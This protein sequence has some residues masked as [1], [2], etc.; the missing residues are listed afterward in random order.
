MEEAFSHL[1]YAFLTPIL[2]KEGFGLLLLHIGGV[3]VCL[4]IADRS[5]LASFEE[6]GIMGI[7]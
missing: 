7:Y 6:M 5:L 3:I 2:P 4:L 1:H